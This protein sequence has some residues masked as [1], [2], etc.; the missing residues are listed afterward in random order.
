MWDIS[1]KQYPEET[2]GG[3][4]SI[5]PSC[6]FM[7]ENR[8]SYWVDEMDLGLG[9]KIS[10]NTPEGRTIAEMLKQVIA[11][12]SNEDLAQYL[13]MLELEYATTTQIFNALKNSYKQGFEDG[14]AKV[15]K[16]IRGA[17][18]FNAL[19]NVIG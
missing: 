14:Q 1:I 18:G 15:Q 8:V 6:P 2:L 16:D 7:S 3:T 10:K 13:Q 5:V 12:A 17:L 11:G 19:D 4:A 9:I